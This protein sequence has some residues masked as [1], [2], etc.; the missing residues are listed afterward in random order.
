MLVGY[1]RVSTQG[2]EFGLQKDALKE[3]DCERM[4]TD[5]DSAS[6]VARPGLDIEANFWVAYLP[7][8]NSIPSLPTNR[9]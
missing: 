6:K 1:A 3:V 9:R 5:V 4:Y 8:L 7:V 2:Q